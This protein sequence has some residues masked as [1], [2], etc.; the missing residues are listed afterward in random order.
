MGGEQRDREVVRVLVH[1]LQGLPADG[2][3]APEDG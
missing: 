1:H 2:A 3:G